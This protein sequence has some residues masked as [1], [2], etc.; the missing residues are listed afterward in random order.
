ME[1]PGKG[2]SLDVISVLLHQIVHTYF[3][4]T[5]LGHFLNGAN[6]PKVE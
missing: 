5:I 2:G 3:T 6:W 4:K 1:V